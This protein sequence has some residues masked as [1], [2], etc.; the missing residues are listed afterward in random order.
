MRGLL[1][2]K[3]IYI[4][5]LFLLFIISVSVTSLL[6]TISVYVLSLNE[7]SLYLDFSRNDYSSLKYIQKKIK[8]DTH[9]QKFFPY[10][11]DE[12]QSKLNI[13]LLKCYSIYENSKLTI[14]IN[15]LEL[16]VPGIRSLS[17]Y[18][19]PAANEFN[20]SEIVEIESPDDLPHE[21]LIGKF[22]ESTEQVV[23]TSLLADYM[24]NFSSNIKTYED[25]LNTKNFIA[26]TKSTKLQICG[27]VKF[28]LEK[29]NDLKNERPSPE[30][31]V[32]DGKYF[33]NRDEN[34]PELYEKF[35]EKS[36]RYQNLFCLKGLAKIVE[37][38]NDVVI[39]SIYTNQISFDVENKILEFN[40]ILSDGIYVK[41]PF[42]KEFIGK[43][44]TIKK[45][46]LI[47]LKISFITFIF[48]LILETII[49]RKVKL[50]RKAFLKIF[51]S[52]TVISLLQLFFATRILFKYFSYV[53]PSYFL[54]IDITPLQ[55]ILI[56]IFNFLCLVLLLKPIVMRRFS[57]NSG[58][59]IK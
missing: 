19:I 16:N 37:Q 13:R 18:Y 10:E 17:Y 31:I 34:N 2:L 36:Y 56:F 49:I 6:L 57:K 50:T 33:S 55:V 45:L 59:P 11:I 28:P 3:K 54:N 14:P 46:S 35:L 27:I 24:I 42:S 9:I 22:P 53:S 44:N 52:T 23:I 47:S 7:N 41:K 29:F 48:T 8:G 25:L 51:L 20:Y 39:S 26:I 5:I 38:N 32:G 40:P 43:I 12:L 1:Y 30:S 15:S 21:Q 58:L 4:S